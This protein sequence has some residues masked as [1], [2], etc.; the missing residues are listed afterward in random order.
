MATT[1][2]PDFVREHFPN[3]DP[4]ETAS[5]D[6]I[7]RCPGCGDDDSL[8]IKN[9]SGCVALFCSSGCNTE[10][11]AP[12]MGLTPK[13]LEALLDTVKVKAPKPDDDDGA[14]GRLTADDVVE[15]IL[16]KY[17]VGRSTDGLLFAVPLFP[18]SARVA[19]E[20][21]SIR[22]DVARRF[23]EEAIAETGKGRVISRD[24][25]TT[26]LDTVAAYAD[27]ADPVTVSIRAAQV[28]EDRLVLD[29]GDNAGHL[30]EITARGWEIVTAS[31][32]SPLFRRSEATAPLPLPQ[33][34]GDLD[35]LRDVLDLQ[36]DDQRWSLIRGWLVAALFS[37]IPRPLLWATGPQGSGKSTRARM[38]LSLLEP[39]ESLGKEPGK[40]ERDDSTAARGRFLVSYDNITRV[41]Q[42][43][44]D[45]ICRLVTGVTDDRRALYTD[46]GLRPVSYRRSG[47][48]TSLTIPPGLGSDALER[49]VLVPFDRV[50]IDERRGERGLWTA[51]EAARPQMLGALL[52]LVVLALGH[53]EVVTA[54]KR[55]RPRMADYGNVLLALDRGLDIADDGG[56][57][58]AFTATA[59]TAQA[60]R[61]LDDPFT[62]AVLTLISTRG[63]E[64]SGKFSDLLPALSA[65]ALGDRLPDWWPKNA[66]ALTSQ[67]TTAHVPLE[68]A[69]VTSRRWKSHGVRMVSLTG[70]SALPETWDADEDEPDADPR[71]AAVHLTDPTP[72]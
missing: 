66:R 41:S 15:W 30:V 59:K 8:K 27:D 12:A 14:G 35:T 3:P 63:G 42:S 13:R 7:V 26:A 28:G 54:E 40:N 9:L 67:M 65:L 36:A 22:S 25:L 31:D 16:A 49:L 48:A 2:L 51:Y 20:V 71:P 46:D 23:R 34:G 10:T 55:E 60:D 72:F 56:H 37:E 44:S 45:W 11:I 58:A 64:W 29:L 24:M 18:G 52:D 61:A 4:T 38:V 57:F 5:G 47:V 53:L 21:R 50:S 39:T 69:G 68:S 32:D 62:L 6:F 19:R 70:P 43:T 1:S 17:R 33:R